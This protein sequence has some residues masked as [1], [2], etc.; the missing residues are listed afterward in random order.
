MIPLDI[1]VLF[2]IICTAEE[3]GYTMEAF[4]Y[5]LGLAAV[6]VALGWALKD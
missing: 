2:A 1:F 4:L 6:I 5:L 3:G